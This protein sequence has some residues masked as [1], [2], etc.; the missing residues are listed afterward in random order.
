MPRKVLYALFALILGQAFPAQ[1]QGTRQQPPENRRLSAERVMKA[2]AEAYPAVERAEYRNG[3]WAVLLKGRWFYWA[4]GRLLSEE[5]RANTEYARQSFYYYERD[6]G[7]WEEPDAAAAERLKQ[8]LPGRRANPPLRDP[9]FFDTLWEARNSN[10]A[11]ANL[12]GVSFLGKRFSVHKA[13]APKLAAVEARVRE[14]AK[15]DSSINGWIAS[16]GSIGAWSW[17]NV[18]ATASR[19]YHSY[20][21]ALDIQPA[22]LQG[23]ATY[24]QWTSDAGVEWYMTPYERRWHPPAAVIR[25]F[26]AYGFCWG[27]KWLLFDTMHF[28]YRPEILIACGMS[29]EGL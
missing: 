1:G 17:R 14:A 27:G 23:L 15:S 29:V 22:R 9:D 25:A 19:S 12:V 3:D 5:K 7:P 18:A 2:Y 4:D 11:Y 8:I 28:E 13:L 10:E 20:G 24:W 21:V 16:L 6:L 26:E